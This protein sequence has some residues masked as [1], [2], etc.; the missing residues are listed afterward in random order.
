MA[1]NASGKDVHEFFRELFKL[2]GTMDSIVDVI[3]EST[4][5]TTP[6]RNILHILKRS[7][8]AT[9][10]DLAHTL[11]VSRQFVLKTCNE[12]DEEG[13]LEFRDNPRHKRSKLAGITPEGERLLNETQARENDLVS[14]LLPGLKSSQ[15]NAAAALMRTIRERI[16][17]GCFEE[18]LAK[19]FR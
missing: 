13:L 5:M 10:P 17:N 15:I 3:H 18:E 6:K 16:E 2:H 4:G 1:V 12:L 19:A 14:A 8:Q 11:G 7:G 9:V